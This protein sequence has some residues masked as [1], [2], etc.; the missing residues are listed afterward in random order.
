MRWIYDIVV[1]V[2]LF[3][4]GALTSVDF[5]N[6]FLEFKKLI[7]IEKLETSNAF[8]GIK[9]CRMS[10]KKCLFLDFSV[11]STH[12]RRI[13][14]FLPQQRVFPGVLIEQSPVHLQ[15]PRK[16][17]TRAYRLTNH[18]RVRV[19]IVECVFVL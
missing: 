6:G 15:I 7:V 14:N 18:P 9:F 12:R 1:Y 11:Q 10:F 3:F 2:I 16:R 19:R 13:N 4:L 8:L 17:I 5:T